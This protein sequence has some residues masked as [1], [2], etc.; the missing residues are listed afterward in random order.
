MTELLSARLGMQKF[1]TSVARPDVFA[2]DLTRFPCSYIEPAMTD[3]PPAK[4]EVALAPLTLIRVAIEVEPVFE[5]WKRVDVAP[6]FRSEERRV[7]KEHCIWITR[8]NYQTL[9]DVYCSDS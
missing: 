5:T 7:G 1:M 8:S 9:S 2:N 4:V 3:S 6:L